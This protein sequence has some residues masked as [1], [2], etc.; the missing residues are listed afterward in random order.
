MIREMK[1]PG[2]VMQVVNGK[3]TLFTCSDLFMVLFDM[4]NHIDHSM[5][6]LLSSEQCRNELAVGIRS[7]EFFGHDFVPWAIGGLE[8]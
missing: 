7:A 3:A 5:E 8:Q 4:R 2:Q 1:S 6:L